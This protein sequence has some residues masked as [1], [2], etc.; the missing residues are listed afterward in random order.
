LACLKKTSRYICDPCRKERQ[1]K[2]STTDSAKEAN[3][4]YAATDARKESQRKYEATDAAKETHRKY[5]ATDAAKEVKRKYSAEL[6]G[7]GYS[8]LFPNPFPPETK[9]HWHHIDRFHVVAIPAE[10]HRAASGLTR[11]AHIEKL[12]PY[13]DNLYF[14]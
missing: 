1:R 10:I 9:I 11:L 5:E 8:E 3:R 2:Y 6:R 12:R 13:V 14:N 4:K 7:M